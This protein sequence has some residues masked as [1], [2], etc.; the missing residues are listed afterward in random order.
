VNTGT[1]PGTGYKWSN[2]IPFEGA[3]MPK[4]CFTQGSWTDAAGVTS[5]SVLTIVQN[6]WNWNQALYSVDGRN[7][8][9]FSQRYG[10]F[11]ARICHPAEQVVRGVTNPSSPSKSGYSDSPSS[12]LGWP[13]W[14]SLAKRHLTFNELTVSGSKDYLEL[15]FHEYYDSA[16]QSRTYGNRLTGT[17]HDWRGGHDWRNTDGNQYGAYLGNPAVWHTYGCLWQP[18]KITWYLD[19]AAQ[20]SIRYSSGAAPSPNNVTSGY[21]MPSNTFQI[22]DL[23]TE[24]VALALGTGNG[25][26]MHVDWVRVW[27]AA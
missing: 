5:S 2:W 20:H 6:R 10:Y 18:G 1:A 16:A 8:A 13:A 17:V 15:D 19:G 25:Y 22:A 26:P 4:S 11:E 21:V 12:P 23:D 9:G 27:G 7:G 3:V 14:W 24:G